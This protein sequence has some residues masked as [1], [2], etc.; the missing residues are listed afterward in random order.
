MLR[1][2]PPR[3]RSCS[4]TRRG[5]ARS[6]RRRRGRSPPNTRCPPPARRSIA[7]SRPRSPTRERA[8]RPSPPR[9]DRLE[10]REAAAGARGRG[11]VARGA[12]AARAPARARAVGFVARALL[13]AVPLPRDR[14]GARAHRR[15]RAAA[16]RDGLGRIPGPDDRRAA[17]ARR[18][19]LRRQRAPRPRPD[20]AR[21][22]EPAR[23]AGAARAAARRDRRRR[24][25]DARGDPSRR[26][27]GDLRAR[28]TLGHDRRAARRARSLR[29][30]RL[31]ARRGRRAARR[32]AQR[33]VRTPR[34]DGAMSLRVLIHVQHLLGTGHLRRAAALG[35]ALAARGHAVV[36]ASGGWP[37]ADLELGGARLVQLPAA[38]AA[39]ASFRELIGADGAPL[40]AGW[41]DARAALLRELFD[42]VAPDVLVTE[43][44]PFGR[45]LI[46]FELLPLIER[47]RARAKRPLIVSSIRDVLAHKA[48]PAKVARMA[49]RARALYDLVLVHGD[50]ALIPLAASFP[51][52]DEIA[53]MTTYTGYVRT[54]PGPE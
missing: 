25:A 6:A 15:R 50:P 46:E 19:R 52:A 47:A 54:P 28:R 8:H 30:A 22:R 29:A 40:D 9:A 44:F 18:R 21:R 43:L 24:P 7:S 32:A 16:D 33:P 2:S 42:R 27:P 35:A 11:A 17:R 36:V 53:D 45:R 5:G 13:A 39:D 14:G 37:V 10:P 48:D 38:R 3:S 41:R 51:S 34:R 12:R 4:T 23:G 49:K 1:P 31:R 26:D 20:A